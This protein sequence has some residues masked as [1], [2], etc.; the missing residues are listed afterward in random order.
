MALKMNIGDDAGTT[1]V[2]NGSPLKS[3]SD[4]LPLLEEGKVVAFSFSLM[5]IKYRKNPSVISSAG[6]T[7]A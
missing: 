7:A 1:L 3:Q 5:V 2:S 6:M 4:G